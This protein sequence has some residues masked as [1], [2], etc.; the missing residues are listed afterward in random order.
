MDDAPGP[1]AAASLNPGQNHRS[2]SASDQTSG[3]STSGNWLANQPYLL[4]SIMALPPGTF[5]R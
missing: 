2:M 5:R 4:L 1:V 3:A